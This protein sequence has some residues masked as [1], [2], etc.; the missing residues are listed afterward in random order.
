LANSNAVFAQE[1][2]R[3][4]DLRGRWK[5]EIGDNQKWA[6]PDFDD[7]S[8]D[9]IVVPSSWEDEGFPGYD[10]YAWYRTRFTLTP[11]F[12][13]KTI[14][15]HLGRVDDVDQLFLN[16]H[17]I[18]FH[19][20][21]PPDYSTSYHVNR[22]YILP[23]EYLNYAGENVIAVRVFDDQLEGGIVGGQVGLFELENP[24][25]PDLPLD[26][27]WRFSIGDENEWKDPNFDDSRWQQIVVPL[28][29]E[30]QGFEDYDGFAWYRKRF[31]LTSN[32]D[33]EKLILVLGKIDDL[34]ETFLNGERIGRTG[35]IYQ[36]RDRITIQGDEWLELRAYYI[37]REY[38]NVNGDNVIAVR[39]YDGLIGGGI[40]DG[41]IGIVTQKEYRD[42]FRKYGRTRP[43]FWDFF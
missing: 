42:W 20:G 15:L 26:G 18:G 12:R 27:L 30:T 28:N 34:D 8:W 11:D 4:K 40:Y 17:F 16:G 39:V 31:R 38:L 2:T 5:F 1:W 21:F 3:L 25:N 43:S 24:L 22:T 9:E 33:D 14:Y 10:G 19:G 29:W 13:Q 23:R 6:Q 37:P 36:N 7:R 41:P 32:Y 35:R